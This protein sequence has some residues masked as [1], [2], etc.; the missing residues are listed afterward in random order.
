[1]RHIIG[2]HI[3]VDIMEYITGVLIAMS[4]DNRTWWLLAL[5]VVLGIAA[6]MLDKFNIDEE[7]SSQK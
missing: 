7:R 3:I 5:A 2:R 1:M 6:F 4:I